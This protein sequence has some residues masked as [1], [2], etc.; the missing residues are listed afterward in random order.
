MSESSNADGFLQ[1]LNENPDD[2]DAWRIYA[3]WLEDHGQAETAQCIR[4]MWDSLAKGQQAQATRQ[5]R[6]ATG[7]LRPFAV[8]QQQAMRD[9]FPTNRHGLIDDG[10]ELH[11][12]GSL[13]E[14]Q[15]GD[16]ARWST[17]RIGANSLYLT[18]LCSRR[19]VNEL[20]AA[21]C[22]REFAAS[23][24]LGHLEWLG[25]GKTEGTCSDEI[26]MGDE[27][28]AALAA[29]PSLFRLRSLYIRNEGIGPE[30]C[31]ALAAAPYLFR[32]KRLDLSY[33]PIGSE[34]V[35]AL[36]EAPHLRQLEGLVL[37][38]VRLT[39][40]TAQRLADWQADI[41]LQRQAAGDERPLEIASDYT[42][43]LPQVNLSSL[44]TQENQVDAPAH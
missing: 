12:G 43:P 19:R 15:R 14:W 10:K 22:I 31:R 29:S 16:N 33:N 34:G 27:G 11:V 24:Q 37:Y 7:E 4:N 39:Q 17:E 40:Q 9:R 28:I 6:A 41:L 2:Q 32:L 38:G 44:Q 13:I 36:T 26:P 25:T 21:Q 1:A 8:A 3:D 18:E 35:E 5:Q 42:L 23:P 20:Q 30:G